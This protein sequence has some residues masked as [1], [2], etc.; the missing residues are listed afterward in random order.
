MPYRIIL[1]NLAYAAGGAAVFLTLLYLLTGKTAHPLEIIGA[2]ANVWGMLLIRQQIA[3][4]WVTAIISTLGIGIFSIFNQIYGQALLQIGFFLPTAMYALYT[5]TSRK[6]IG[7]PK[8]SPQWLTQRER[9]WLFAF[10]ALVFIIGY[11]TINADRAWVVHVSDVAALSFMM[12]GQILTM[13][14]KKDCWLLFIP[15]NLI[16]L[17]LYT[18]TG[19]YMVAALNLFF[20]INGIAGFIQWTRPPTPK[21]A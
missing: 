1:T 21:T 19:G 15:G 12:A 18:M 2:T 11:F 10:M 5:W 4:G 9:L 13:L 14:R 6:Y 17:I 16:L 20:L 3:F 8:A 7:T